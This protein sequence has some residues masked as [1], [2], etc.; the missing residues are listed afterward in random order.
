[1]QIIRRQQL[2]SVIELAVCEFPIF[3]NICFRE[4]LDKSPLKG[5]NESGRFDVDLLGLAVFL[6]QV[7]H[8][9]DVELWH[10]WIN[11]I[12]FLVDKP[13]VFEFGSQMELLLD[14]MLILQDSVNPRLQH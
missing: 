3:A 2:E 4:Q 9:H 10:E 8:F 7:L 11:R 1:M 13:R 5:F 6:R 12:A 14:L